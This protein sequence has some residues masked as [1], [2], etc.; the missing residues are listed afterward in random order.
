MAKAQHE[1]IFQ[2]ERIN[3]RQQYIGKI[4]E[5]DVA[6]EKNLRDLVRYAKK[7]TSELEDYK[8]KVEMSER[9][10]ADL[11]QTGN[12]SV[13]SLFAMLK[14]YKRQQRNTQEEIDKLNQLIIIKDNE[15]TGLNEELHAL[16][17]VR[18]NMEANNQRKTEQAKKMLEGNKVVI[19]R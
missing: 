7:I 5:R 10:V 6:Q 14:R 3:V 4:E 19:K 12:E 2:Q 1:R 18:S 13:D 8:Q 9:V 16:N 11:R 17:D 15:I